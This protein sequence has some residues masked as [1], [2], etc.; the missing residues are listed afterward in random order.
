MS[1]RLAPQTSI[2]S[3][4][5]VDVVVV[6]SGPAGAMAATL[7]ARGGMRVLVLDREVHTRD[8]LGQAL[9]GAAAARVEALGIADE[10]ARRFPSSPG[11]RIAGPDDEAFVSS[12]RPTWNVRRAEFDKLLMRAS[13]AAG[14]T[15]RYGSVE[16]VLR[17]GER[18]VGV[19]YRPRGGEADVL[20]Q[21]RCRF[22]V[23]ASGH[24]AVLSRLG[25][26]GPRRV[27]I[28]DRQTAVFTTWRVPSTGEGVTV[29]FGAGYHSG[30]AM[31]I[32]A[33]AVSIGVVVPSPRLRQ[34]GN[35][36]ARLLEWGLAHVHRDFAERVRGGERIEEVR[37]VGSFSYRVEPFAG[38]GWLCAGDAHRFVHPLFPLGVGLAMSEGEAAARAILRAGESGDGA[39]A[40]AEYAAFAARGQQAAHDLVRYFWSFPS[41]FLQHAR[42]DWRDDLKR[43]LGGDLHGDELPALGAMRA[44]LRDASLS[45][46]FEMHGHD[47]AQK[48]ETRFRDQPDVQA[49]FLDASLDGVR[50]TLVVAGDEPELHEAIADFEERLYVE[51]NRA[52]LAV[53]IWPAAVKRSFEGAHVLFDKRR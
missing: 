50:V 14:A 21:V 48:V 23:D 7:L 38:D 42:T 37:T 17:D 19:L 52:D 46:R 16:Q 20:V 40:F 3:D 27:D 49:A 1:D 12:A 13:V 53:V 29:Y 30:W 44:S 47:I 36:P 9:D 34:E 18:V 24:A 39:G 28:F 33:D 32:G 6:G 31:P 15:R 11:T 25:I 51:L 8:H 43:L 35:D 5:P 2:V 41:Q 26:A 4:E 45:R 22:L 10:V